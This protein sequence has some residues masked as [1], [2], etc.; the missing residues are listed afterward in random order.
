MF[1]WNQYVIADARSV[2][3]LLGDEPIVD[4]TLTSPPYW[5][6]KN[7]GVENQIGYNQSLEDYLDDLVDVFTQ[8][9]RCTKKSGSLWVVMKSLKKDGILHLLPF[10]LAERLT[11][12]PICSWHLQDVLIWYK[13][14]TLPWSHK[15]KL[16]DNHEYILCFS[17][18]NKFR[19]NIDAVRSSQSIGN[20][21][22]KYPERYHPQGKSLS[23]VWEMA[24]PTQGSWG[25]GHMDHFCPL[26][27]E[28]AERVILL[29]TDEQG[30][31]LDP[32]AGTGTTP[33]AAQ[34]SG[35]RWFALDINHKYREMFYRR[36]AHDGVTSTDP[37]QN[38]HISLLESNLKLRQL[39]FAIQLFKRMAPSLRLTSKELPVILLSSGRIQ[40][41][42]NPFWVKHATLTLVFANKLTKTR[43]EQITTA[44]RE[45]CNQPPLSKFQ[46]EMGVELVDPQGSLS[47]YPFGKRRAAYLYS[48]GIF[49]KVAKEIDP[50]K[51]GSYSHRALFP[52]I[53]SDL[54]VD[55]QP[56]Y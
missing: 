25:N 15:Q 20:W 48:R 7:Y 40:T 54:Q 34:E 26:P 45:H 38:G 12:L 10:K 46:V 6:L 55:E 32:F 24:I 13:P 22:V 50:T 19:L 3:D 37:T 36:L 30:V 21:W 51:L 18:S 31:V 17:K 53:V 41:S 16:Q 42:P 49:W 4:V 5:D 47:A 33:L 44:V 14:H 9:W 27:M 1:E 2:T 23:N 28:L 11:N 8:V 35:R 52:V 56:A 29:S 43:R 39:K